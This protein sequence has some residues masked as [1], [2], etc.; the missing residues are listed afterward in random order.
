MFPKAK[1]KRFNEEVNCAPAPNAYDSQL[2]RS[3]SGVAILKSQRFGE[4]K[5]VT[6]GPGQYMLAP[7]ST[8]TTIHGMKSGIPLLTR[9][10]SFRLK[11][12]SLADLGNCSMTSEQSEV[13]R[14]P[15]STPRKIRRSMSSGNLSTKKA[16]KMDLTKELDNM[17]ARCER[18][19]AEL[20]EAGRQHPIE[21]K[22]QD[23]EEEAAAGGT[24]NQSQ[25]AEEEAAENHQDRERL[26]QLEAELATCR[27]EL[28]L[29]KQL[30]EEAGEEKER[31][32]ARCDQLEAEGDQALSLRTEVRLLIQD[33]RTLEEQLEELRLGRS[34]AEEE[35]QE[36]RRLRGELQA[37]A[38]DEDARSIF[39]HFTQEQLNSQ[40]VSLEQVVS[41]LRQENTLL[42]RG[43]FKLVAGL[44]EEKQKLAELSDAYSK[45]NADSEVE[46]IQLQEELK[47]TR[48][49]LEQV[50]ADSKELI[51]DLRAKLGEGQIKRTEQDSALE[52]VRQAKAD[53]ESELAE[54]R[55]ELEVSDNDKTVLRDSLRQA[56][57]E[58]N[59][60]ALD[61]AET[62][63]AKSEVEEKLSSISK[64]LEA[65][66]A[67]L[68]D[69]TQQ[70]AAV[71][72]Q[73]A[74]SEQ[75]GAQKEKE[76]D[77]LRSEVQE[78][79]M[80]KVGTEG[81][82][83]SLREEV[84]QLELANSETRA[85]H[86]LLTRRCAE[87][88][89]VL[90]QNREVVAKLEE[91]TRLQNEKDKE[92]SVEIRALT[93]QEELL[94][95]EKEIA[96][97]EKT[98]LLGQ[99]SALQSAASLHQEQAE[100]LQTR[101]AEAASERAVLESQ[102]AEREVAVQQ[103]EARLEE[104]RMGREELEETLLDTQELVACM[105]HKLEESHQL[106]RQEAE[107]LC[108]DV[109]R[110]QQELEEVRRERTSL[111]E[112]NKELS[113]QVS[114]SL[115]AIA[116]L[117][118]RERSL[119]EECQ[120]YQAELESSQEESDRDRVRLLQVEDELL[121]LQAELENTVA[122]LGQT[123]A[124]RLEA[125]QREEH[126]AGQLVNI[127]TVYNS[128]VEELTEHKTV[129]RQLLERLQEMEGEQNSLN[130]KLE[131]WKYKVQELEGE[132]ALL[133]E[134]NNHLEKLR[135]NLEINISEKI[136]QMDSLKG[137]QG[138][139]KTRLEEAL[140]ANLRLK[141]NLELRAEEMKT[142]RKELDD[143]RAQILTTTTELEDT[144]AQLTGVNDQ[145]AAERETSAAEMLATEAKH[146]SLETDLAAKTARVAELE[147]RQQELEAGRAEDIEMISE[148]RLQL[149]QASQLAEEGE[150]AVRSMEAQ[151]RLLCEAESR[152]AEY[153]EA[154]QQWR[155]KMAEAEELMKLM[156]VR[157][158][159]T[160]EENLRL[161]EM[162]EP[163]MEQL[164]NY[165][166]EKKALL[167]RSQ[168][169]QGELKKLAIQCGTLLGHQNQK[170]K[171]HHVVKLKEENVELK[172]EVTSLRD[173]LLKARRNGKKL[174]EKLNEVQGIRRFSI[175]PASNK[176]N[177]AFS[178]P[179]PV[180]REV[181]DKASR[182]STSSARSSSISS[183]LRPANRN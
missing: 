39:L 124:Q 67:E 182:A 103:L 24:S 59:G 15:C 34:Q 115:H 1:V 160:E 110:V 125:V 154:L 70:L 98:V 3:K 18:L 176:E 149:V 61:L 44:Q 112:M 22:S 47:Q 153:E 53:L 73:L 116:S 123:E 71:T 78:L 37:K 100:E 174:E 77:E 109:K 90:E 114:E 28:R 10:A 84:S 32:A 169:D 111:I 104:E 87:Q 54:Q 157:M 30:Y 8:T 136:S 7:P 76:L 180:S 142:M 33:N 46:F 60:L 55:R 9:S 134:K 31:L 49:Q 101:A 85:L 25:K 179:L 113:N 99:V 150:S 129:G 41:S 166:L 40:V 45:E 12:S 52:E 119:G 13:F 178:T 74:A 106:H 75:T 26:E 143:C 117:Q 63:K 131:G 139:T 43:I 96:A 148:L 62:A 141:G 168:Q 79:E 126:L 72:Q 4:P 80:S 133:L 20:A 137:E 171:I 147:A 6:P 94:K 19:E 107:K 57:V 128:S 162:T 95:R 5:Y 88:E 172:A 167:S 151:Q 161:K 132:K 152:Q 89:E 165:E 93:A 127:K 183:P 140:K 56:E 145:L 155:N 50:K 58:K 97:A 102:A 144:K 29:L 17:R 83:S 164:E 105:E 35:V 122:E 170:Q 92:N 146:R 21:Q 36:V 65:K 27:E 51:I 64:E 42:N 38:R 2:P 121:S 118:E 135:D 68:S 91:L 81:E 177:S 108:G 120:Y 138:E 11:K 69:Q 181:L 23:A 14:T 175:Q 130:L 163:F 173:Q 158:T 66:V 16:P 159:A 82:L 156:D 48:S 86:Q